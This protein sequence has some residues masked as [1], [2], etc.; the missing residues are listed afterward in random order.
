MK[1][2]TMGPNDASGIVWAI[3][4]VAFHKHQDYLKVKHERKNNLLMAQTMPDVSFGPFFVA[5]ASPVALKHEI[6]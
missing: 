1:K 5:A 6:Y 4:I 2:L 3:F